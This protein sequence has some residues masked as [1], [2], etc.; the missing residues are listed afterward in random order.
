MYLSPTALLHQQYNLTFFFFSPIVSMPKKKKTISV[1]QD[2][3][4]LCKKSI[5][6]EI[7]RNKCIDIAKETLYI[8]CSTQYTAEDFLPTWFLFRS[9]QFYGFLSRSRGR[10][11]E[12][13]RFHSTHFF[14]L[15][16]KGVHVYGLLQCFSIQVWVVV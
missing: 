8:L 3:S 13:T 14:L 6:A 2:C 11:A 12:N 9:N 7:Y 10:A 15:I 4:H 5:E 16:R 1:S